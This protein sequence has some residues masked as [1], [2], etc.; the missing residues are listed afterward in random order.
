MR[1]DIISEG[2]NFWYHFLLI[3]NPNIDLKNLYNVLALVLDVKMCSVA[4][5]WCQLL[6]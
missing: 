3:V 4:A 5:K 6:F 2:K 1:F